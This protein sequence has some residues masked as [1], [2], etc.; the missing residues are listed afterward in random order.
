MKCGTCQAYCPLYQKDFEEPA[1]AR[2]K[3]ALIE[4]IYEGRFTEAGRILRH[5]DYCLLCG[6]CK[7]NCPS[8]VITDE[9]FIRAKGLLRKIKD[10]SPVGKFIL[11]IAMNKPKVFTKFAPFLH[12]LLKIGSKNVKD[13]IVR[14]YFTDRNVKL[15]SKHPLSR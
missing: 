2:G 12:I 5:L 1:V 8:G 15:F 3:I 13:D 9:I 14:P 6:R 10:L 7:A 11:H 4:A